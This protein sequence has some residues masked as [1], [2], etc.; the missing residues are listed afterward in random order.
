MINRKQHW[1]QIYIDKSPLDVSW[2]QKEPALSLG[3]IQHSNI[4]K[5]EFI[6]DVGGGA[7]I[8]VDR[9]LHRGY[10]RLA[11][12]DISTKALEVAKQRLADRATEIEWHRQDIT[13]FQPAHKYALWHDRAVFHF[14]IEAADRKKYVEVLKRSLTLQGHLILA[15]FAIGGPE[16]CSGLDIVQ[17]DSIKIS[18]ELG[19]DFRLVEETTE[20]HVTPAGK[21]QKFSYFRFVRL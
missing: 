7:S 5:D 1:D 15:A 12:L 8:L 3:L 17:Y 21:E 20:S 11:V 2:Y 14:L 18:R 6:I 19:T 10:T 4:R 16:R 9:L 13:G